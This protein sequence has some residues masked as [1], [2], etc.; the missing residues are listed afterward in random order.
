M[1]VVNGRNF[2][3]TTSLLPKPF[4][5]AF[6]ELMA[7]TT[8]RL[9]HEV[10]GT[11][12]AYCYGDEVVLCCRGD[13]GPDLHQWHDGLTQRIASSVS[14]VATLEF[15]RIARDSGIPLLGDALFLA[16]CHT[17][18]SVVE[19]CNALVSKQ[20]ECFSDA[21]YNA[22]YYELLARNHS[23]E[24]V[25]AALTDR[26]SQ[27]RIELLAEQCGIDFLSQPLTARA[28]VAIMRESV[29][30]LTR[31]GEEQK[32]KLVVEMNL[33]NFAKQPEFLKGVFGA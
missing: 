4:S 25:R 10:S 29:P 8:V 18:P 24:S 1:I 15:N 27:G 20:H 23:L 12:F 17:V 6:T 33:P 3:K 32:S 30:Q 9:T 28:G 13:E 11:I 16:S 31:R 2:R 26:S 7:A 22:C 21:L 19:M 5:E 14:A